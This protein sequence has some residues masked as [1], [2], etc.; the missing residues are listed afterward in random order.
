MPRQ[1]LDESRLHPAIR[2]KVARHH[3][4]IVDEVRK[5]DVSAWL[6]LPALYGLSAL[7]LLCLVPFIW[8]V[9]AARRTA[10]AG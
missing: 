8:R 1:V 7:A 3:A 10:A 5:E 2:E 4:D 6:S 9:G